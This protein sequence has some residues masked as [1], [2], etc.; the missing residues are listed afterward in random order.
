MPVLPSG[1]EQMVRGIEP[2]I[3]ITVISLRGAGANLF[4]SFLLQPSSIAADKMEASGAIRPS[5]PDQWI[6]AGAFGWLRE[7][8]LTD[9]GKNDRFA[10]SLV[11][12]LRSGLQGEVHQPVV[13]YIDNQV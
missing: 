12:S 9:A 13:T 1:R 6:G 8:F 5:G 2:T 3:L 4:V 11:P 10:L 7:I